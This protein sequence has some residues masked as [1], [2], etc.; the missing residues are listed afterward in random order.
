MNAA[1]SDSNLFNSTL[2]G[3]VLE[4][5]IHLDLVRDFLGV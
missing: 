3:D 1:C 5:G 2:V 4:F